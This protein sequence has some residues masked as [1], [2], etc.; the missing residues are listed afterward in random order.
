MAGQRSR[1]WG[2]PALRGDGSI[3]QRG[4]LLVEQLRVSA[5]EMDTA[6]FGVL[7]TGESQDGNHPG[8]CYEQEH[9]NNGAP[10][11]RRMPTVRP[12]C[13]GSA[14]TVAL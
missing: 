13:A 1:W 10:L 11:S 14:G 12:Q 5:F 4:R 9:E 8:E 7:E 3:V 6:A 2:Q